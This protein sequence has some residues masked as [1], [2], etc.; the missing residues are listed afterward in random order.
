ME[1]FRKKNP[2]V[3]TP[4]HRLAKEMRARGAKAQ[5]YHL[6]FRWSGQTE[7]TTERMRQKYIP[8]VIIWDEVCIVPRP[9]SETFLDWLN[10]R[11]VQV[12]CCGDQGRRRTTG[13]GGE[14]I[15]MKRSWHTTG[16]K[17]LP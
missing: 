3:F 11:G 6:F 10:G 12:V 14:P 8:R 4:T 7:W 2:L 16:L 5:T 17:N 9:I 15:T 1:L 13:C